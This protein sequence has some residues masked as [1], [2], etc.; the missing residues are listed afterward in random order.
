MRILLSTLSAPLQ[1]RIRKAIAANSTQA[2]R[3]YSKAAIID[4]RP[5]E[6]DKFKRALEKFLDTLLDNETVD[7]HLPIRAFH[8][9]KIDSYTIET[10]DSFGAREAAVIY[11]VDLYFQRERNSP[12]KLDR[13][14]ITKLKQILNNWAEKTFTAEIT[15][16][17]KLS[18][19]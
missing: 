4:L 19:I 2:S 3:P 7:G 8:I 10:P 13:D 9:D 17:I 6:H 16:R 1:H 18:S 12:R 14:T 15:F 11:D 5:T